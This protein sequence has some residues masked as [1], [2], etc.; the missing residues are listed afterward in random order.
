[1]NSMRSNARICATTQ[2]S[3]NVSI[4]VVNFNKSDLTRDCLRHIWA[5]THKVHYE[6]IVVDNGS[7]IAEFEKLATFPGEF[8]LIRLPV[9]RFFGEGT[10]I[11]VEASRGRYVVCLNNDAFVGDNWLQPLIEILENRLDAGGVGA[12]LLSLDGSVQEAGAVVDER[13]IAIQRGKLYDLEPSVLDSIGV[14]DYCSSACFA[15]SRA[16]YDR[17]SGF[18]PTFDPGYYEDTD[19]CLRITSLGLSIYYCPHS[20][21]HHMENATTS[22]FWSGVNNIKEINRKKFLLRWGNY[23]AARSTTAGEPLPKLVP[24]PSLPLLGAGAIHHWRSTDP[25]AVFH[26]PYE[27]IPDCEALLLL[28]AACALS[29]SHRVYVVTDARYSNYRLDHLAR[30]LSLDLSRISLITSSELHGLPAVDVFCC[31]DHQPYP[32]LPA[33]G[34]RNFYMCRF[35]FFGSNEKSVNSWENL[36]GYDRVFVDSRFAYDVLRG[37]VNAFQFDTM[38]EILPPPVPI[39]LPS[40]KN[41]GEIAGRRIIVNVGDHFTNCKE[42]CQNVLIEGIKRLVAAGIDAELHLVGAARRDF[43]ETLA[44]GVQPRY[45]SLRQQTQG[46]PVCLH[47]NA[48]PED[49]RDILYRATVYWHSTGFG[50]D[51]RLNPENCEH[52][53]ADI[54]EAMAVGCIPFVVANGGPTEFVREGDTGFQYATL[55]ELIAKTRELLCDPICAAM[56][57]QR[58]VGEARRFATTVFM[59]K[60]LRIARGEASAV[61]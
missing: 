7:S 50:C 14:V 36:R 33:I 58:A 48:L 15:T 30:D 1:M 49:V 21:A 47:P 9:N 24:L 39:N 28:A 54:L 12:K 6:V 18:D 56:M 52:F 45:E 51:H 35:P 13:G 53:G 31:I 38:L 41:V 40:T 44:Y 10:N 26:S 19:L 57:S 29:H 17:V 42:T 32:S 34:R 22:S 11:G 5:H 46:M 20:V 16:I 61:P 8:H 25:I 43:K 4:V 23:L 3:P 27:L 59:G 55:D 2:R 37:K 60:W